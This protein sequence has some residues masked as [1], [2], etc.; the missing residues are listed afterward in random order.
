[1]A[2]GQ[3]WTGAKAYWV[4]NGE[5]YAIT[6][7]PFSFDPP[8]G[9]QSGFERACATDVPLR[10]VQPPLVPWPLLARKA[11]IPE[12]AAGSLSRWVGHDMPN[13]D[14]LSPARSFLLCIPFWVSTTNIGCA[15]FTLRWAVDDRLGDPSGPNTNGIYINQLPVSPSIVGGGFKSV[16][17]ET[18]DVTG[19]V[20]PGAN[21]LY[22]YV[23]DTNGV[24]SGIVYTAIFNI[25]PYTATFGTLTVN[26]GSVNYFQVGNVGQ[27]TDQRAWVGTAQQPLKSTKFKP[28]DF[29]L[30]VAP[31][32]VAAGPWSQFSGAPLARWIDWG[33][34]QYP[35]PGSALIRMP[36]YVNL[37]SVT[38]A[39]MTIACAG[40][41]VLGDPLGGPN[42][43]GVYIGNSMSTTG[44]G[45]TAGYPAYQ[46]LTVQQRSVS[47][48]PGWNNLYLYV[49]DLYGGS[50]GGFFSADF[51]VVGGEP[52]YFTDPP[53]I[54]GGN[55]T[56]TN[57]LRIVFDSAIDRISA[58]NENNY[59]L[60]SGIVT[61]AMMDIDGRSVVLITQGGAAN[62]QVEDVE[63]F[64]V[65]SADSTVS[66]SGA[67]STSFIAGLQS[68]IDI[69][70][71]DPAALIDSIPEDRSPYAGTGA[72][73]P[74]LPVT[75]TGTCMGQ[76]LGFTSLVV[77]TSGT[78]RGILVSSIV[79]MMPGT[80][81]R[82][83][84]RVAEF[85]GETVVTD[86]TEVTE[87]GDGLD[88]RPVMVSIPVLSRAELDPTQ[89]LF[90]GEDY[91]GMLVAVQAVDIV[92][93][94]SN[95]S[96]RVKHHF[97]GSTETIEVCG[98]DSTLASSLTP[99]RRLNIFGLLVYRDGEFKIAPRDA[100]DL[101][102]LDRSSKPPVVK[103]QVFPNP[104][105]PNVTIS[106]ELP[107]AT[108]VTLSIY[109]V[110]GALVR[111]LV[112]APLTN[113]N[114]AISWDGTSD[115]GVRVSSGTYFY[116][117]TAGSTQTKGKLMILK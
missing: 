82:V 113:G 32:R 104:A 4:N 19:L 27:V 95:Q 99:L 9:G 7:L 87:I 92:S 37:C 48:T 38:S 112:D 47:L 46:S 12:I 84:G 42:P 67:E 29:G 111:T 1:M 26:S 105:N 13:I 65:L 15:T 90:T 51:S 88:P 94:Y 68:I 36:F 107:A 16:K 80:E 85:R 14:F 117:L 93:W 39:T 96:I 11:W 116:R 55:S 73:N 34:S 22:I 57:Q 44:V 17:S 18:R 97:G 66:M 64:G 53:G 45:I 21:T 101:A 2:H 3:Y 43:D 61:D 40:D 83:S 30:C 100:G 54:I 31:T 74:G 23:R 110:R 81:Y 114:H 79:E 76:A 86:V 71:P 103:T 75:L 70:S 20:H 98:I 62:G 109:D 24:H 58:E 5:T 50:A 69:Q 41:D 56:G 77:G 25:C 60:S 78:R 52:C 63:V 35:Y 49:R 115:K 28:A 89:S 91:E 102:F 8:F 33:L 106:F 108:D 59:A 10:V 6:G 72:D